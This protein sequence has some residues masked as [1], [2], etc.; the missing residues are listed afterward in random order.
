[1]SPESAGRVVRWGAYLAFLVLL[2]TFQPT[3]SAEIPFIE[4]GTIEWGEYWNERFDAE[5]GDTIRVFL[6]SYPYPVDILVFDEHGYLEYTLAFFGNGTAGLY[7]PGSRL[8]A[9]EEIYTFRI[10]QDGTYQ[11]V[12][13]NSHLPVN[14]A[15][16]GANTNFSV[17]AEITV[18]PEALEWSTGIGWVPWMIIAI[19]V[20]GLVL[21]LTLTVLF[22]KKKRKEVVLLPYYV[23]A[24]ARAQ[25]LVT[26][27]KCGNPVPKGNFCAKCG[28]RLQ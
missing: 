5:E 28:G 18:A 26:C 22:G 8:N 6:E 16:T 11:F 4:D 17:H 1:M 9:T 14:G 2:L 3:A 23:H 27:S 24:G 10:P 7:G 15:S 25:E 21:G 13:D 19:L 12:V 20:I